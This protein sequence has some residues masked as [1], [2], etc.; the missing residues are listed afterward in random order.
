MSTIP[1][2]CLVEIELN[3]G[4]N[5][6]HFSVNIVLLFFIV[7][8]VIAFSQPSPSQLRSEC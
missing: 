4:R 6:A 8:L 2:S 7:W 5:V 1:T 3:E